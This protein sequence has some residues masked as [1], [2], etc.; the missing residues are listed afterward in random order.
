VKLRTG[1]VA[2]LQVLDCREDKQHGLLGFQPSISAS[3][4]P[5]LT[6][7]LPLYGL[8]MSSS[9]VMSCCNLNPLAEF[10]FILH[11]HIFKN[12]SKNEITT[13]DSLRK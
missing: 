13:M 4:K 9:K 5:H 8:D 7:S 12:V 1:G 10:S 3:H 11:Y 2:P 6:P